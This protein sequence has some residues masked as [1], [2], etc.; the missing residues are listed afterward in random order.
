MYVWMDLFSLS[1]LDGLAP[2]KGW[3]PMVFSFVPSVFVLILF[4]I[5]ILMVSL[6]FGRC[7]SCSPGWGGQVQ[8][9]READLWLAIGRCFRH[10]PGGQGGRGRGALRGCGGGWVRHCAFDR[11]WEG[12]ASRKM[13]KVMRI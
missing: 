9:E 2:G 1:M 10:S 8:G 5:L 13:S 4:V 12:R 7:I 3:T 11:G 6:L